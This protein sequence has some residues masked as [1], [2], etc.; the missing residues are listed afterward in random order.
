[1]ST[2]GTTNGG[3]K[4]PR[5]LFSLGRPGPKSTTTEPPAEPPAEPSAESTAAPVDE[6]PA[7]DVT[8]ELACGACGTTLIPG[9]AFCGEC[10]TPVA[11][12]DDESLVLVEEVP[13]GDLE[14][15]D[16][17]AHV[18]ELPAD[19]APAVLYAD[20]EAVPLVE[21]TAEAGD[22]DG[23]GTTVMAQPAAVLYA[24]PTQAE[25]LP[26]TPSG[27]FEITE[28]VYGTAAGTIAEP[29]AGAGATPEVEAV[30]A[31]AD[32]PAETAAEVAAVTDT[33]E[34]EAGSDED[35]DGAPHA[36][37]AVVVGAAVVGTTAAAGAV[38]VGA[39][40][41]DEEVL[42]GLAGTTDV[43]SSAA[44]AP[45]DVPTEAPHLP[46]SESPA[47]AAGADATT[48]QPTVDD[49]TTVA[50][51]ATAV[52]VAG[53][54]A[55]SAAGTPGTPVAATAYGATPPPSGGG[56]SKTGLLVGVAAAVV[57]VLIVGGI[58]IATSG[59]EK[60]G[61]VQTAQSTTTL[62][63]STTASTS[64]TQPSTTTTAAGVTS[65]TEPT[66]TLP[67]TE[68]TAAPVTTPT[69]PAPTTPRVTVTQAPPTTT[70]QPGRIVANPPSGA[71]VSIPK[72][73]STTIRLDN[74]G[75]SAASCAL[76]GS[77]GITVSQDCSPSIAP[78]GA[79]FV[80]IQANPTWEGTSTVTGVLEGAGSYVL[81][82]WVQ[83]G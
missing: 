61:D 29:D 75:G 51:A 37:D 43:G 68:T 77:T 40:A 18:E 31:G 76:T 57:L 65:T 50:P 64:T 72:G 25:P 69:S 36:T 79:V 49:P 59:G 35:A 53:M 30:P 23:V 67:S 24:D 9:A 8:V 73:G 55:S 22:D 28:P 20:A 6:V 66:T 16:F 38:E 78:G 33:D 32:E 17:G 52:P 39:A 11:R 42:A 5:T 83:N 45:S 15:A 80:T 63:P 60:D 44:G 7:E 3:A 56:S 82:V 13:M 58:I 74:V 2:D 19:D 27:S 12:L 41:T 48:V 1:M 14:D 47:A 54:A 71:T 10:G 81:T 46:W 26:P 62:A 4:P 21:P 70:I 34:P